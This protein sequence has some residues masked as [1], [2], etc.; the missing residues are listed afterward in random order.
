M[1][2]GLFSV[3]V[4]KKVGVDHIHLLVDGDGDN[5]IPSVLRVEGSKT[6]KLQKPCGLPQTES[7]TDGEPEQFVAP[8]LLGLLHDLIVI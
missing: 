1:S 6:G 3:A 2:D 5:D 8:G 7:R 4:Q